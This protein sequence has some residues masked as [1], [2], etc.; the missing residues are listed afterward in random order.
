MLIGGDDVQRDVQ[1]VEVVLKVDK[2]RLLGTAHGVGLVLRG[3]GAV[4]IGHGIDAEI[5]VYQ[6]LEERHE[7][8][9]FVGEI[10]HRDLGQHLLDQFT[11]GGIVVDKDHAVQTDIQFGGQLSQVGR[12][13][14]PVDAQGAEVLA[15]EHHRRVFVPCLLHVGFI[16]LAAHR[17]DHACRRELRQGFLPHVVGLAGIVPAQRDAIDAVL[18][19]DP[20]PQ[21][22]VQIQDK[23]L[24]ALERHLVL[25]ALPPGLEITRQP[26]IEQRLGHEVVLPVHERLGV[27]A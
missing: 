1:A 12:L 23:A 21:G 13:V 24:L 7:L 2:T 18:A 11:L 5:A 27:I 17:Q 26:R 15:L 20:T 22:I 16:V 3:L 14:V 6:L 8:V 19:Q 9:R 25:D 10:G 4:L